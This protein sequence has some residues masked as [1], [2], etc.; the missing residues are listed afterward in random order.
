MH[1]T[2][3]GLEDRVRRL[4]DSVN[5]ELSDKDVSIELVKLG[6][7]HATLALKSFCIGCE[8]QA[9][10]LL[11]DLRKVFAAAFGSRFHVAWA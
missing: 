2:E 11:A 10:P 4:L 9:A 6:P 3:I 8:H 1:V 7:Q 5:R